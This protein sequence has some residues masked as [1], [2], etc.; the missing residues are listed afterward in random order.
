MA[1]RPLVGRRW[2]RSEWAIFALL[3]AIGFACI[4]AAAQAAIRLPREWEAAAGMASEIDPDQAAATPLPMIEPLR[5]EIM[6]PLWD[7]RRILTPLGP[8]AV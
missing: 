5:P 3:L 1:E 2:G 8:V 6:T 4:F 7:L